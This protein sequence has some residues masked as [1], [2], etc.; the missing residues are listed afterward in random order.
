MHDGVTNKYFFEI[1]RK[2]ITLVFLTPKQIYEKQLKLK[3][4]KM[5]ENESLYIKGTFFA[6]K[7]ILSFNDDAIIWLDTD[8]L[9][10]KDIFDDT[11]SR[12]IFLKRWRMIQSQFQIWS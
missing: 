12:L 11:H 7:V 4:K 3:K 8:L 6:N 2:P 1:N 5:V 10:L 9:T